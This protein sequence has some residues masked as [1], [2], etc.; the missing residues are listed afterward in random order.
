[1]A[2]FLILRLLSVAAVVVMVT[3]ITWLVIHLLRPEPFAG[4]PRGLLGQPETGH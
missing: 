3:A 2:K 4:D 1:M